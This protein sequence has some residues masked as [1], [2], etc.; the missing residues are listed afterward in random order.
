MLYTV[1]P[2]LSILTA[3]PLLSPP[4]LYLP[5]PQ[6]DSTILPRIYSRLLTCDFSPS[7]Y[8]VANWTLVSCSI[9]L[10]GPLPKPSPFLSHYPYSYCQ[11]TSVISYTICYNITDVKKTKKNMFNFF[12]FLHYLTYILLLITLTSKYLL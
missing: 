10:P 2:P 4:S 6:R 3:A 5:H 11:N 8:F 1:Q 7:V 12:Y 9:P